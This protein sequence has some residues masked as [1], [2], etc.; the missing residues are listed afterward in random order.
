MFHYHGLQKGAPDVVFIRCIQC[1][2][3]DKTLD[4]PNQNNFQGSLLWA[5]FISDITESTDPTVTIAS[6]IYL[7]VRNS[8][9]SSDILTVYLDSAGKYIVAG[10]DDGKFFI[11]E[12]EST[13]IAK[14]LI[15][16]DSIVNCLQGLDFWQPHR[17]RFFVHEFRNSS[18]QQF[19]YGLKLHVP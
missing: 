1:H 4:A 6:V 7:H 3:V 14:I 8:P 17:Q 15:G 18:L 11:W 19:E 10:S 5:Q 2:R 16:D 12:R 9:S 13:N